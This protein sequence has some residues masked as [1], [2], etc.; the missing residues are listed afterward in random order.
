MS[1]SFDGAGKLVL[2]L[3]VGGLIILHGIHKIIIGPGGIEDMV[4]ATGFPG[5]FGWA[6]YLGEVLGP[7]LVLMGYYARIGGLLILINMIVAVLLEFGGH[8]W[9]L[10][11]H[12]GW[13]IELEACYGLGGLAIM[14]MGAGR[15]SIGRAYAKWN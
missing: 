14:L 4:A 3:F 1:K 5:A 2:R 11:S 10:N 8:V 9:T 13:V 15:Y 6:V 7:I 12:G